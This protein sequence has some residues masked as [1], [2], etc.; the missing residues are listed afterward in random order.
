MELRIFKLTVAAIIV[1]AI[2]ASATPITF[3]SNPITGGI[4][5]SFFGSSVTT[6]GVESQCFADVDL[7]GSYGVTDFLWWGESF[8]DWG[9]YGGFHFQIFAN[10]TGDKPGAE[11]FS[12]TFDGPGDGLT[13]TRIGPRYWGYRVNL[14]TPFVGAAGKYWFSV[15]AGGPGAEELDHLWG[16]AA[17]QTT[18]LWHDDRRYYRDDANN[19][20]W[21]TPGPGDLAFEVMGEELIP[22]PASLTLFGIGLASGLAA[23]KRRKK[24][25]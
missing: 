25:L 19:W 20:F 9:Q 18:R 4:H 5:Q 1:L 23:I 22:E 16:W 6:R 17:S 15:T 13:F 21:D 3:I 24:S 7:N 14:T 12:E 10:D 2:S 11:V 8:T